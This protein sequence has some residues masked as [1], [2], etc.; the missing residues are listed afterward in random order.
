MENVSAKE[1]VDDVIKYEKI[2]INTRIDLF[3]CSVFAAVR[4]LNNMEKVKQLEA[5][6]K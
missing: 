1:G 6:K 4:M 2:K 5:L 3:D